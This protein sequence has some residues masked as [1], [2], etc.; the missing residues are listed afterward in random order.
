MLTGWPLARLI[1]QVRLP[2]DIGD[3]APNSH[4]RASS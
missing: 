4:Q 3:E 1:E 2:G